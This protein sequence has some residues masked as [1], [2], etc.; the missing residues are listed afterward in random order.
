MPSAARPA[1]GLGGPPRPTGSATTMHYPDQVSDITDPRGDLQ[2]GT[3]PGLVEDAAARFGR[4]EAL[5]DAHG[6]GG[7]TTRLTFAQRAEGVAAATRAVLSNGIERGDRIAIW[8]PNCAEWVVAALGAVG[9]GAL[10]VPLNTRCKGA[11]AAYILREAGARLLFTV[12]GFLGTD[13]PELLSE[14]A[15]GGEKVPDIERVMVRRPG[16][17]PVGAGTVKGDPV[18][19]WEVFLLEGGLCSADVAAG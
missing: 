18:V 9:A 5:V 3:V 16:D 15:A 1:T 10:L 11:E 13:Y 4:T 8:A 6:P 2:W 12:K 14:A 19:D 17:G 7:T